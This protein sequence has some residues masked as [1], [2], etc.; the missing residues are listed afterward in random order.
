[1]LELVKIENI[2]SESIT[3]GG[4]IF[5]PN[6]ETIIFDKNDI[7]TYDKA[8]DLFE[9]NWDMVVCDVIDNNKLKFNLNGFYF[10]NRNQFSDLY[11]KLRPLIWENK[12]GYSRDKFSFYFDLKDNK[13]KVYNPLLNKTFVVQMTEEV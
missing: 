1:M 13:W 3:I 6:S 4:F 11:E 10:T 8:H 7:S 12:V 2:T 9:Y 5:P